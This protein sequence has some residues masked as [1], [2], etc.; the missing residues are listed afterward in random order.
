MTDLENH[1]PPGAA[2]VFIAML[3]EMVKVG[4]SGDS[5][6]KKGSGTFRMR[7]RNIT[8]KVRL[9]G[10][11]V[12]IPPESA[13]VGGSYLLS[14]GTGQQAFTLQKICRFDR[15]LFKVGDPYAIV[16]KW[17]SP[18]KPIFVSH[19]YRLPGTPASR[20]ELWY[21]R[22]QHLWDV[23]TMEDGAGIQKGEDEVG[24][25]TGKV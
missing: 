6:G 3:A 8:A 22:V 4:G 18:Q 19:V 2:H 14:D 17:R 21:L 23:E 25:L 1:P 15:A 16:G 9:E 10:V 7:G 24:M 20:Q 13:G 12:S 5:Q 11:I